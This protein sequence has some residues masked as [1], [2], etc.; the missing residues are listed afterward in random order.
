MG[1][2][3]GIGVNFFWNADSDRGKPR[4]PGYGLVRIF[5]FLDLGW[6]GVGGADGSINQR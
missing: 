5:L 2:F 3:L 4:L 6:C 1:C